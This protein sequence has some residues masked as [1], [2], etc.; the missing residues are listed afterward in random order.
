MRKNKGIRNLLITLIILLFG[1]NLAYRLYDYYY[2]T[3]LPEDIVFCGKVIGIEDEPFHFAKIKILY[4]LNGVKITQESI[5]D[6]EG[7][8][9]FTI[10]A[11]DD[12]LIKY[13]VHA[14]EY[15][16]KMGSC[17]TSMH[18]RALSDSY[19]CKEIIKLTK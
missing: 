18:Y 7:M 8:F 17:H 14:H 5:T 15:I 4:E 13:E 2:Y 1:N 11:H 9:R 19:L 10:K 16:P 3:Y 12:I 6:Y